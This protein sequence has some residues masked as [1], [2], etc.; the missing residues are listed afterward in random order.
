MHP[1][2][3][4]ER[5][6]RATHG[7]GRVPEDVAAP[8]DTK[9]IKPRRVWLD[10]A[11]R[12]YPKKGS[13]ALRGVRVTPSMSLA[14]LATITALKANLVAA[15]D[16]PYRLISAIMSWTLHSLTAGDGP[17]VVG[18]AHSDYTVAEI[19]EAIE[20][21]TAISI[22]L[23]VQQEQTNRLVRVV[24]VLAEGD[25]S[26]NNGMPIKTR[27]NWKFPVGVNP[28]IFAYNDGITLTTGAVLNAN[29]KIWVKDGF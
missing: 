4:R 5:G 28:V 9:D 8:A 18:I 29:G 2:D 11:K 3:Q 7:C 23:K 22:G 20:A 1:S 27:L 16:G 24:G 15:A 13:Y 6:E 14:T 17:I 25:T 26:L 10:M 21:A 19:K 12:P